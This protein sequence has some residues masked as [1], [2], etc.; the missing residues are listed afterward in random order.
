MDDDDTEDEDDADDDTDDDEDY[1]EVT[2]QQSSA[3]V[4]NLCNHPNE[5]NL[6]YAHTGRVAFSRAMFLVVESR[7]Q[8]WQ[9][10]M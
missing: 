9:M 2:R 3:K 1:E 7:H 10:M 8:R 6:S 4:S 5:Q